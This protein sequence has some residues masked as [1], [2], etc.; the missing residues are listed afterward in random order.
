MTN[1]IFMQD[2]Q[3]HKKY[4]KADPETFHT[5]EWDH[6]V[7]HHIIAETE[8]VTPKWSDLLPLMF[9]Q[10]ENGPKLARDLAK[11]ELMKL[12]NAMDRQNAKLKPLE[13]I[14]GNEAEWEQLAEVS[15]QNI[16]ESLEIITQN[17]HG[18]SLYPDSLNRCFYL[19]K[20]LQKILR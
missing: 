9:D 14:P 13:K 19:V 3:D 7:K 15:M 10:I 6:L 5:E 2:Y 20:R 18:T 8:D 4:D 11:S 17:L 16:K 1:Y 12:A